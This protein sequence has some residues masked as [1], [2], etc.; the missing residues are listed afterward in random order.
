MPDPYTD[1][2]N[3]TGQGTQSDPYSDYL[4]LLGTDTPQ[5]G[6][7]YSEYLK[8]LESQNQSITPEPGEIDEL[9]VR[10]PVGFYGSL[11]HGLKSGATLGYADDEYPEDMTMGEMSGLLIGE[12]AGGLLPLG[13]VS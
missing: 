5:A 3:L 10:D 4:N 2:L 7:P 9:N 11:V 13:L 1:Y 6:D 12:L 8:L